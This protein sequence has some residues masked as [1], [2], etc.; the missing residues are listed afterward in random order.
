[1]ATF[2]SCS[3]SYPFLCGDALRCCASSLGTA[4]PGPFPT[5]MFLSV[6]AV[7]AGA[8][9]AIMGAVQLSDAWLDGVL[10]ERP[11]LGVDLSVAY[12]SIAV[13][14]T[15][16]VFGYSFYARSSYL[17]HREE[18]E[19]GMAPHN[20][21]KPWR[22]PTHRGHA[23][24]GERVT[25]ACSFF[26]MFLG[27]LFT[28][29]SLVLAITLLLVT[30]AA[31]AILNISG[32]YGCGMLDTM[33]SD[34]PNVTA[35]LAQ[36][37][38]VAQS[39]EPIAIAA[40]LCPVAAILAAADAP[41]RCNKLDVTLGLVSALIS[42]WPMRLTHFGTI[43]VRLSAACASLSTSLATVQSDVCTPLLGGDEV[44]RLV[45]YAHHNRAYIYIYIL[46][47]P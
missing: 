28:V 35:Q 38:S 5:A 39:G 37:A 20:A 10:K 16:G 47:I 46:H 23:S 22:G 41:E 33:L 14:T 3:G 8:V 32:G 25:S 17:M 21:Q 34:Y 4:P 24:R 29:S 11:S 40:E 19:H 42:M 13:F 18:V 7:I 45:P 44:R 12:V 6:A 1:M 31:L 2:L 27:Q 43:A 15:F 36:V 30:A 26:G 9:L